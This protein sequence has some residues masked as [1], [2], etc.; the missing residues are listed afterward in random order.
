MTRSTMNWT[1]E[2]KGFLS[3]L[4]LER[5]LS[6]NS[7]AAYRRDVEKLASY[8]SES[9]P[10]SVST[11]AHHDL[12]AFLRNLHEEGLKARSQ[13]RVVSGVR[14]FFKYLLMEKVITEDPAELL[15]LPKLGTKL[16]VTLSI[17][18]IELLMNGIDLSHPSGARDRTMLEVLYGCGLRVS[19]LTELRISKLH[20]DEDYIQVIG[21]G[22]KE[23]LVPIGGQA[24]RQIALFRDN[25]RKHTPA[26]R[27]FEDHLFLNKNGKSLSR[28]S[29]FNFVK[30][31]CVSCGI[32]KNVSPHTF[33]HSFAT[34]LVNGGAD[35]RAVQEML[36]HESI[37]TTEIYSHLDRDY[38][39][40]AIV[41]F[42]PLE[43]KNR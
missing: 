2:I 9:N 6:A 40:S 4:K 19:E 16:P 3:Y 17:E 34:H 33:R 5:S 8:L 18:E 10:K 31:L 13:A 43:K 15:E 1:P 11:V 14:A 22:D 12:L 39:R 32:R 38:L 7:I 27:G 30:K 25:D 37:T 41:E 36:G 29:V 23:R 35:L 42:H 24:K 21:K 26:Q 28:V 20:L